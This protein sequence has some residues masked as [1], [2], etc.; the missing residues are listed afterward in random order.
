MP[1]RTWKWWGSSFGSQESA[2]DA[3]VEA[4]GAALSAPPDQ[5]GMSMQPRC[6]PDIRDRLTNADYPI[7]TE[8][9]NAE[10][11]L[12]LPL[13]PGTRRLAHGSR[14]VH[15]VGSVSDVLSRSV[16]GPAR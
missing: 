2:S 1:Y 14:R 3:Q 16:I 8:L 9:G 13:P 12:H 15:V 10:K 4:L 6:G 7:V 5:V 11:L